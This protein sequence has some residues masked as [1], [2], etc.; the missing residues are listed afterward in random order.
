MANTEVKPITSDELNSILHGNVE[1]VL[2]PIESTKPVEPIVDQKTTESTPKEEIKTDF[3]MRE[4][5]E[6]AKSIDATP[7]IEEEKGD[8]VSKINELI[9]QNVLF[10]FED[11]EVKSL[12]DA[13]E[14]IR[15]NLDQKGQETEDKAWEDKIKTYSPQV[16]AII[17]YA[18]RGGTDITPLLSAI[19]EAERSSTFEIESEKGQEDIV[20]EF[21][22]I[23]G[24]D[25][26]DIDEEI[27]L[28]KDINKLKNKAEK[29]L[30]RLNQMREERIAVIMQEQE[31]RKAEAQKLRESYL[32]TLKGTLDKSKVGEVKLER[33][34]KAILWDALTNVKHTSWNGQP[35]TGFYKRLEELQSKDNFENY[36]ELVHL[37]MDRQGFINK[38]RT[39]ITTKEAAETARKLKIEQTRKPS[40][41]VEPE[42]ESRNNVVSRGFKNPYA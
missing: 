19:S 18:E 2:A 28:S 14:L 33:N 12:E 39:E 11:G 4:L 21:L 26:K 40:S 1:S 42:R 6:L 38:L 27:E 7:K 31:Q 36:L 8:F 15:L 30:P 25:E 10:G 16:Q 3:T 20:R 41:N 22:K 29:F 13:L 24:W 32:N 17:D 9:E 37:A 35:V 34:D 23:S 5:D